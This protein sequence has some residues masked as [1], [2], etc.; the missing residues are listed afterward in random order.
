MRGLLLLEILAGKVEI[1]MHVCLSALFRATGQPRAEGPVLVSVISEHL[2]F[3]Y[4]TCQLYKH[5]F[6]ESYV[7]FRFYFL[8]L[9]KVYSLDANIYMNLFN[10]A[11]IFIS[12]DICLFHMYFL[13]RAFPLK[14]KQ[15]LSMTDIVKHVVARAMDICA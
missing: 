5:L 1:F 10:H 14:N 12:P 15:G 11:G 2:L 7:M 8:F 13:V 6:C 3:R 4:L 9:F